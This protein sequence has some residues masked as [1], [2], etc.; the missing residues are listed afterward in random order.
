M[1]FKTVFVYEL[2]FTLIARV[3]FAAMRT[4]ILYVNNFRRFLTDEAIMF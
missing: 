3:E 1:A 4:L 2:L